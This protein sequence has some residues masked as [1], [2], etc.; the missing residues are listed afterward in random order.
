[1]TQSYQESLSG[2][3]KLGHAG[4]ERL[5]RGPLPTQSRRAPLTRASVPSCVRGLPSHGPSTYAVCPLCPLP[6][7]HRKQGPPHHFLHVIDTLI[8]WPNIDQ[9]PTLRKMCA[10]F[11][12]CSGGQVR[13][14]DAQG[15]A[16]MAQSFGNRRWGLSGARLCPSSGDSVENTTDSTPASRERVMD[17]EELNYRVQQGSGPGERGG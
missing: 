8:H 14:G 11:R 4:F 5:G 7:D 6:S 9:A 1:M 16:Q 2:E 3:K 10:K 12:G 13:A 17:S 15:E